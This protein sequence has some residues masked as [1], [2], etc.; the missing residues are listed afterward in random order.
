MSTRARRAVQGTA[1]VLLVVSS[2][3]A[4]GGVG[5][6]F[7][8]GLVPPDADAL[9]RRTITAVAS[10]DTAT[11]HRVL[12]VGSNPPA[13]LADSVFALRAQFASDRPDTMRLVGAEVL[14]MRGV[15]Y[16]RAVYEV[17]TPPMAGA[18]AG[19]WT[20]VQIGL[21]Q[22]LGVTLVNAI[23]AQ[24]IPDA[25]ERVNA[26]DAPGKGAMQWLA[27]AAALAVVAYTLVAAVTVAR[28]PMPKRWWWALLALVGAGRIAVN[29]TTGDLA[30]QPF[31][32]QVFGAGA[33]RDGLV[34]PWFITLSLPLGA[35]LALRHRRAAL[36]PPGVRSTAVT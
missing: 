18:A 20:A 21:A 19:R 17:H 12:L 4:C 13:G 36:A 26:F 35:W 6:R 15:R 22:E 34:G 16:T 2:L 5:E 24:P 33:V 1:A 28:T 30:A 25:L 27:L 14:R 11:L 7:I 10:G 31:Y 29:W 9:A 8:R 23:R 3:A 32:G